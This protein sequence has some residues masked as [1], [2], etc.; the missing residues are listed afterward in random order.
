MT[1]DDIDQIQAWVNSGLAAL[2]AIDLT[3]VTIMA[4]IADLAS[5]II[6]K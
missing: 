2:H 4:A 3:L 5:V 1:N 6:E